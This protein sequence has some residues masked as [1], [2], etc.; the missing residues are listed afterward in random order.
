MANLTIDDIN[1]GIAGGTINETVLSHTLEN[2]R[3]YAYSYLYNLQKDMVNICKTRTYYR[4][5]TNVSDNIFTNNEFKYYQAFNVNK[6]FIHPNMRLKFRR[7]KYYD[8]PLT[9]DII[10]A[11]REDLFIYNYLVF[12]N[13]YLD[14]SSVIKCKEE[15]TTVCM[16][17]SAMGDLG[18]QFVSGATIDILFLQDSYFIDTSLLKSALVAGNY[19]FTLNGKNID[20]TS[21]VFAFIWK[22]DTGLKRCYD[23][24]LSNGVLTLPTLSGQYFNDTETM[25][26]KLVVVPNYSEQS[27]CDMNTAFTKHSEHNMPVPV[28]NTLVFSKGTDGSLS[29]DN[30]AILTEKYPSVFKLADNRTV[31]N[32]IYT[33]YWNNTANSNLIFDTDMS[34]YLKLM[35]VLN[36]YLDGTIPQVVST[37]SPYLFEYDLSE[38]SKSDYTVEKYGPLM[39]KANK[40]STMFN[41]WGFALQL[42]YEMLH[43]DTNGYILSLADRDLPSKLRKDNLTEITNPDSQA[44]FTEDRYVFIFKNDDADRALPY[45]F[46]I[47]G[48]RYL[49]DQLYLDGTYEYVYIPTTLI[50][51][52]STIEIEI[53]SDNV[54]SATVNVGTGPSDLKFGSDT[55]SCPFTSLFLVDTDG[56]YIDRSKYQITAVVNGTT[57]VMDAASTMTVSNAS[58][59][60][61]SPMSDDASN[62]TI[63][64]VCN[65][66]PVS[67]S[68]AI[69]LSNCL[70]RNLNTDSIINE[71]KADSTRI[72]I[73]KHGL[74]IPPEKY[75]ITF[76]S[77]YK[78]NIVIDLNFD[79]YINEFEVDYL[80][81][82]YN[83]VYSAETINV[84]GIVNLEGYINKPF[85]SKYYDIYVNGMRI[86]PAQIEKISNF[87]VALKDLKTL[88]NLYV[89]EKQTGA[90]VFKFTN[91]TS[92][93][94]SDV[95]LRTDADFKNAIMAY[96]VDMVDDTSI[97]DVDTMFD[98][99]ENSL[100]GLIED[101]LETHFIDARD[102]VPDTIVTKYKEFFK[103]NVFFLDA[104]VKYSSLNNE[105]NTYFLS[106]RK[107]PEIEN[108]NDPYYIT[109]FNGMLEAFAS[110]Y[111]DAA[112]P[113]DDISKTYPSVYTYGGNITFLDGNATT[114]RFTGSSK[115]LGTE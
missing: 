42:Y 8:T 84:N 6:A 75:L 39:Y 67:F 41:S 80:P 37:Y 32:E 91:A 56:N 112:I 68:K 25:N 72:R 51:K 16:S 101:Y 54:F 40:I 15:L 29:I 64:A 38:Y 3:N 89:Y 74:L 59:M 53:S 88:R 86:L 104:N 50:T 9:N 58:A 5:F 108:I 12:V 85:S 18:T 70:V 65:D 107:S 36:K 28:A 20:P 76:P 27:E 24:T 55:T 57:I 98:V 26:I 87:T 110:K 60:Q 1:A 73:F 33:F 111:I 92:P 94:L 77:N 2:L 90:E 34:Y 22:G 45:K 48:T 10:L 95:L 100:L 109:E 43:A 99:V 30:S 79:R 66:T 52:T 105:G 4:H 78:D 102:V 113:R 97:A 63:I 115:L 96:L 71:I 82:S 31:T 62:K 93:L 61:I 23:V 7:S 19:S 81:E 11:N 69:T 14:T 106:P 46:W 114:R 83:V 47:D 17:A 21:K 35:N 49:P 103:S 13:G 44:T